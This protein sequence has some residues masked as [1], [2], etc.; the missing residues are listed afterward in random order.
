MDRYGG[1]KGNLTKLLGLALNAECRDLIRGILTI[2]AEDRLTLSAVKAHPWLQSTKANNKHQGLLDM[3]SW[4]TRVCPVANQPT[5]P[6][7]VKNTAVAQKL[8]KDAAAT[9]TT[10]T[11]TLP[12]DGREILLLS[13]RTARS[14]NGAL[15]IICTWSKLFLRP[16]QIPVFSYECEREEEK[17]TSFILLSHIHR[18]AVT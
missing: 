8:S 6:A 1:A 10:A 9:A 12:T 15:L 14:F 13:I 4:P 2:K 11:P 18:S 16:N 5:S 17:N 7:A 3:T